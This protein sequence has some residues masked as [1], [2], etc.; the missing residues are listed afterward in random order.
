M[1]LSL[2]IR[3]SYN[4]ILPTKPQSSLHIIPIISPLPGHPP[5]PGHPRDCRFLP[6]Q[7]LKNNPKFYIIINISNTIRSQ[8]NETL[9]PTIKDR[10]FKDV[11]YRIIFTY[12]PAL[13]IVLSI[14]FYL[15]TI[16]YQS[17]FIAYMFIFLFSYMALGF[18]FAIKYLHF[19]RMAPYLSALFDNIDPTNTD[20][21]LRL[22]PIDDYMIHIEQKDPKYPPQV[23]IGFRFGRH[24][25]NIRFYIPV[26]SI[27]SKAQRHSLDVIAVPMGC[28]SSMYT[29]PPWS[30]EVEQ[31]KKGT[32]LVLKHHSRYGEDQKQT[33]S[34][35]LSIFSDL[36]KF[37]RS[38]N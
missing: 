37:I 8:M 21:K 27:S 12:Y 29:K 33:I 11:Q 14:Y 10:Y 17:P 6:S 24:S 32:S 1:V 26:P 13:T 5:F 34:E 20:I 25:F 7:S 2:S 9:L 30:T 19:S 16:K 36:P 3:A 22:K 28:S 18:F 4:I 31:K 35:L 15:S 23:D 38:Y